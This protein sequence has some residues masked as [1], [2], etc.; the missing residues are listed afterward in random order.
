MEDSISQETDK[1][2]QLSSTTPVSNSVIMV[3][4]TAVDDELNNISLNENDDYT[5]NSLSHM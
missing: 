3:P 2:D 1:F 4:Q 5:P